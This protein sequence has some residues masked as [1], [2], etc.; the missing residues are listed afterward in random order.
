MK[1]RSNI[2]AG[3]QFSACDIQLKNLQRAIN[4]GD[5]S[6]YDGYVSEPSYNYLYQQPSYSYTTPSY[7]PPVQ[8]L[9]TSG[10]TGGGYVDG[11]Y[12]ADRSYTCG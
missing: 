4:Q 12:F 2:Y 11:V 5:C 1:I 9:T 6:G 10:N 7:L 3:K 8:S